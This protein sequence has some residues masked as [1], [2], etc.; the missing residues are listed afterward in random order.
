MAVS[1]KYSSKRRYNVIHVKKYPS[2]NRPARPKLSSTSSSKHSSEWSS[3]RG[4]SRATN[5]NKSELITREI[6]LDILVRSESKHTQSSYALSHAAKHRTVHYPLLQRLVKGSL[7]WQ[8]R[9]DTILDEA[10]VKNLVKL[11]PEARA[12]MRL[13]TYQLSLLPKVERKKV[14]QE[15]EI[16]LKRYTKSSSEL[17]QLVTA[18]LKLKR[19]NAETAYDLK[20]AS[21]VAAAFAH[22]LWLVKR[23]FELLGPEETVA[24]CRANNSKWP[25]CVRTNLARV[26]TNKLRSLLAREGFKP[27]A[28]IYAPDCTQ[29]TQLAARRRL[30]SYASFQEGLYAIQDESA[31][32][33]AE[34]VDPKPGSTVVDLCAAP[35]GKAT[36]LA[37]LVG[38]KGKVLAFE[39]HRSRLRP[40]E[41][42]CERLG[43]ENV[44]A[45]VGDAATLKL[46]QP[47][48]R[49]LLDAP[50]SGLGVIGRK[51]D[52]RWAKDASVIDELVVLQRQLITHAATLV[53]KGGRLIY[54]TCTLEPRENQEIIEYFLKN[55]P[56]FK[57]ITPP[58][59]R[60]R[61]LLTKE[62]YVQSWPHRHGM[63]GGFVAVI[64]RVK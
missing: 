29:I 7:A 27:R 48:E 10:G 60:L 37:Q 1:W 49:V 51:G 42:N 64:E 12:L 19:E 4:Q 54:S 25:I 21:S 31:A 30:D 35:G 20:D 52:I 61:P 53:A 14:M 62:G 6:A 16:L 47:A 9:I 33:V 40:I 24:L 28:T 3:D 15:S 5:F 45:K 26:N 18:L 17:K 38:P 55:N 50:C 59:I 32:L 13:A 22:P 63:A 41:E 8:S 57:V 36:H 39:L 2:K 11:A 56:D 58:T 44:I 43:I 46:D 23:W 34:L